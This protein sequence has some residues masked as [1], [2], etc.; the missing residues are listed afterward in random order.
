MATTTR[1][2]SAEALEK[3][4]KANQCAMQEKLD[5]ALGGKMF[6]KPPLS[7]PKQ[8]Y[9]VMDGNPYR[10][11]KVF[12]HLHK[13]TNKDDKAVPWA[14]RARI[15]H[16]ETN[17]D[18]R[19][20]WSDSGETNLVCKRHVWPVP[21]D[22]A[23][24][25]LIIPTNIVFGGALEPNA[26]GAAYR[27]VGQAPAVVVAEAGAVG[28]AKVVAPAKVPVVA[29]K[30]PVVA[31][32]VPVV[33]AKV[34][35]V[36]VAKA[37]ANVGE[38]RRA[39]EEAEDMESEPYKVT[40]PSTFDTECPAA[41]KV[42]AWR[43]EVKNYCQKV[44]DGKFPSDVSYEMLEKD[45]ANQVKLIA[46]IKKQL[47][48]ALKKME[49]DK[50]ASAQLLTAAKS[51]TSQAVQDLA[52]STGLLTDA[53]KRNAALVAEVGALK[54]RLLKAQKAA[55]AAVA[56][57]EREGLQRDARGRQLPPKRFSSRHEACAAHCDPVNRA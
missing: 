4:G 37:A 54:K 33:A 55:A 34:P 52:T 7:I 12:A 47:G 46:Q 31:A 24:A 5:L 50:A 40:A 1:K 41:G 28:V 23:R 42:S 25:P 21:A 20:K 18:L 3:I 6:D 27:L 15:V 57:L 39:D 35:V 11:I 26:S 14:F 38:K 13:K 56:Q 29:A 45:H 53:N 32:K 43:Q 19:V 10:K 48:D 17:G 51:A 44:S 9:G 2:P 16:V 36:A 30:V 22:R 8:W 49:N